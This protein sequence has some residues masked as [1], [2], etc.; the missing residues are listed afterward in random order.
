MAVA[1]LWGFRLLVSVTNR[2]TAASPV[3]EV[4]LL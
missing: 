2:L 1:L 4:G 3:D